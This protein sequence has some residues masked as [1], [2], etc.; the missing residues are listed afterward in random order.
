MDIWTGAICLPDDAQIKDIS[1]STPHHAHHFSLPSSNLRFLSVVETARIPLYLAAGP[2]L[3]VW[4]A[5]EATEEWFSSVLGGNECD[6]A[7]SEDAYQWCTIARSQSPTGILVQVI[8]E[9]AALSSPRVSE[10]LFYGT[11][12]KPRVGLPTPP[13]YSPNTPHATLSEGLELRVHALPLSSDFLYRCLATTTPP[14]PPSLQDFSRSIKETEAQFLPSP[15]PQRA[16]SPG[17]NKRKRC[18]VIFDEA[19]ER[20]RNAKRKGGES[21][22][23]AASRADN[24]RPT[25]AH[26]KSLSID[27]KA[28]SFTEFPNPKNVAQA[29]QIA[30]PPLS[31]SPSVSAEVRPLSR[32]GLLNDNMKRSSLSRMA[33]ISAVSEEPTIESRNKEA[34]SRVVMAGMR[35]YGLQQRKKIKSRHGSVTLSHDGH[36]QMSAEQAAEDAAKDEEYKLIYHQTFKGAM[37]ALRNHVTKTP[38]QNQPDRLR[39]TVDKL[40]AIFCT[41]PLAEAIRNDEPTS[42]MA[43]PNDRSKGFLNTETESA[44]KSPFANVKSL[45]TGGINSPDVRRG[46]R[47]AG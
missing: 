33:D 44:Q 42:T 3:D 21:V 24:P 13:T 1:I 30:I 31:R 41:D 20:R 18:D 4:T 2:S 40:L 46:V 28:G 8:G 10:I 6:S 12:N 32:K 14:L 22:A 25:S 29:S 45:Q 34:L 16:P 5:S 36:D 26:R 39:D 37:L 9:D 35:M 11:V 27:G 38:L 7:G 23:A 47:Q 43:T 17:L 15:F 19:T